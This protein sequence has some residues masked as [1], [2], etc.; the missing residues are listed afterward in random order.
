MKKTVVVLALTIIGSFEIYGQ[1]Q[2]DSIFYDIDGKG[3]SDAVFA[4]YCRVVTI[5]NDSNYS[6]K[7]RTFRLKDN[8]IVDEG[9]FISVDKYDMS[10]TILDER[11]ISYYENGN[12]KESLN[13]KKGIENGEH[14]SYYEDGTMSHKYT[15]VNSFR[16]GD[17]TEFSQKGNKIVSEHYVKG[18]KDGLQSKYFE[19]GQLEQEVNMVN[20]FPKGT[21][22]QYNEDGKTL[23]DGQCEGDTLSGTAYYYDENNV[24]QK[25]V[26]IQKMQREGNTILYYP[27]GKIKAIEPYKKNMMNGVYKIYDEAGVLTGEITFVNGL[28][29]GKAEL[30]DGQNTNTLLYKEAIPCDGIFG[31]SVAIEEELYRLNGKSPIKTIGGERVLQKPQGSFTEYNFLRFNIDI[32]NNKEDEIKCSIKN[33]VVS[34]VRKEKPSKNM[35][36]NEETSFDI[37]QKAAKRVSENVYANAEIAAS[38]A[39]TQSSNSNSSGY[40][41]SYG[42][43]SS[44]T[45]VVGAILGMASGAAV[46]NNGYGFGGSYGSVTGAGGSST[47]SNAYGISSSSNKSSTTSKDGWLQYQVYQQE[48]AKADAQNDELNNFINTRAGMNSISTF[49]MLPHEYTRKIILSS[50]SLSKYDSIKLSFEYN[51]TPV[52]VNWNLDE[53]S[54]FQKK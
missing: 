22:K 6:K 10:K 31:M 36:L 20:D 37:Y 28:R 25:S 33:V 13:Y 42:Q 50:Q 9:C 29:V 40:N 21:L 1:N 27:D 47:K 51:G 39:A 53:L 7:F 44:S 17:Y 3:V 46:T 23:F 45:G 15:V 19:N 54:F 43:S 34:F 2:L 35:A 16:D 5:P 26:S 18:K 8:V 12:I 41:S 30:R 11:Y 4:T 38:N 14:I 48:K 49:T 24:L 32:L 52:E